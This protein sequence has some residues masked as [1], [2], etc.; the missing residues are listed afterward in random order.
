M[1]TGGGTIK[2]RHTWYNKIRKVSTTRYFEHVIVLVDAYERR[3]FLLT[4]NKEG[5]EYH[6]GQLSYNIQYKQGFFNR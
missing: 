4:G 2:L 3:R 6:L 1:I 5:F